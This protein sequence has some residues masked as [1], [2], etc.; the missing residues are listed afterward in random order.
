MPA[1]LPAKPYKWLD[2]YTVEDAPIFFGRERETQV[3]LSDVLVN[4]L[5]VL[6]AR[7][8]TGKTSLINAGV[9]P[10]LEDQGCATFFVRVNKDPAASARAELLD[11]PEVGVLEGE[12]LADQLEGV[13]NALERP[14]VLFF[15]QFEE[16]FIYVYGRKDEQGRDRGREFI[17]DVARLYH[18]RQSGVHLVFSMREEFFVE[19]DAFRDDIPT[20]FH[21]E[22]NLRLRHFDASQARDAIVEPARVFGTRLDADLVDRMLTDLA[23]HGD[24]AA[25]SDLAAGE[26]EP[27]Q[28]QIVCDTLW[29]H[30][31][32]DRLTLEHYLGLGREGDDRNISHQVL[33]R[34]LEDDFRAIE[35]RE[36][37]DL[38][39]C[40]LPE[41]RTKEGTKYVR[42]VEGLARALET[43]EDR[44][45]DLLARL[46]RT[47]FIR[48]GKRDL[49][50]VVELSHDYLVER[51][52]ELGAR[53]RTIW[54]QRTLERAWDRF[55]T[56]Q[57]YATPEELF[58]IA[59][60]V[61][62]LAIDRARAEFLFRSG[63][64]RRY[65]LPLWFSV[66]AD[67]GIDVWGILQAMTTSRK[68]EEA[69]PAIHML[70]E[71][72]DQDAAMV[73]RLLDEALARN[74]VTSEA[75]AAL[76][77]LM[78]ALDANVA[79][80]AT[81]R[82]LMFLDA[83]VDQG[84]AAA[85]SIRALREVER[86][87]SVALARRALERPDL[88]NEAREALVW[89]TTA[90]DATIAARARAVLVD[91]LR[92]ALDRA[93]QA[94]SAVATLGRV[95]AIESV[96]LLRRA[97]GRSSLAGSAAEE[98]GRLTESTNDAV[99]AAAREALSSAVPTTNP[100]PVADR[101]SNAV[102]GRSVAPSRVSFG[103]D[104]AVIEAVADA[105]RGGQCIL[106]LGAAIH[107]PPPE[108]SP[109]AYPEVERPPLDGALTA[110]LADKS[111]F[112]TR[113]PGE[114]LWSL[115]RV[116]L[117]FEV[118]RSRGQLINE[119]RR[120]VD[121]GK[122]PSPV[123]HTLARLDFPLVITTNYDQLFEQA[124][125]EA[126]KQPE[127][128]IY[129]RNE[130]GQPQTTEQYPHR[131]EPTPQRPFILKLHGD[132]LDPADSIVITDE[133]HIQLVMRMR[134]PAPYHP[135]PSNFLY[136]FHMWPTLFIG[137]SL[138]DFNLRLLFKTMRAN[139]D[140]TN[141][142]H[143]YFVD[144]SPDLLIYDVWHDR[145]RYV[146]F[147]VQDVWDFV[148][149]LYRRVTGKETPA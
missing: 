136:R 84:R 53:V 97:L 23:D 4:R 58:D 100:T 12:G 111:G 89:L 43:D 10:R 129:K 13:V 9:R 86:T 92:A 71:L 105:V 42:D 99:A 7:T 130:H 49:H 51:L 83:A 33:F 17:A 76:T 103:V 66:A 40:L 8:G 62:R 67:K 65:R 81:T 41:L 64:S 44:L 22:T 141:L 69:T 96:D 134:D 104:P 115:P 5:V 121:E 15:D 145:R 72:V 126:G 79:A 117:D 118:R 139:L 21:N 30:R 36:Q 148:P 128:S 19:M 142:P 48:R 93:E 149:D 24:G 73:Y 124:L 114:S 125:R 56:T 11:H 85:P 110:R 70:V 35:S 109:H 14:I 18:D 38:L 94:S 135:I 20:I 6:F 112:A 68:V 74:D 137:Y 31:V 28:L 45:L 1:E 113:F 143:T 59:D 88:A 34:R 78:T 116:A 131:A 26:I 90:K 3:L 61:A 138:M 144:R 75:Q 98:L 107:V 50:V 127:L 32:D 80:E 120:A 87:E 119:I 82:M 54:P 46:E 102:A 63:L 132:V 2:F 29:P 140:A 95:E 25:P 55:Q 60:Q 101:S 133:D 27:A 16:F 37:L 57:D 108:D 122:R 106:F 123:L 146:D 52:D 39:V 77:R 147:I 91:S 47:R